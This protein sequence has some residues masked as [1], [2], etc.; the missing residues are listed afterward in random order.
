[1]LLWMWNVWREKRLVS[2]RN[3]RVDKVWQLLTV[4]LTTS[5]RRMV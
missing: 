3:A 2:R 5:K 1:M 4:V